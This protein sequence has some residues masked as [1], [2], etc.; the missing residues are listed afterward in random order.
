MAPPPERLVT[1]SCLHG[2]RVWRRVGERDGW[3]IWVSE[4]VVCGGP[5]EIT[6]LLGVRA[7]GSGH[8]FSTVTCTVHRLTKSKSGRLRHR[9]REVFGRPSS[10]SDRR[11]ASTVG[12]LKGRPRGLC[13]LANGPPG[14]QRRREGHDA[15]AGARPTAT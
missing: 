8:A 1:V 9:R 7:I 6:T 5:V 2:E 15:A 4:C 3:A 11:A 14:G 12:S 13:G 10:R